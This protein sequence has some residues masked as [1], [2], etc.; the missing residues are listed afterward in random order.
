MNKITDDSTNK[1]FI[2]YEMYDQGFTLTQIA[3]HFGRS[4]NT[5]KAHIRHHPKYK[6]PK[7]GN[8]LTKDRRNTATKSKSKNDKTK[9]LSFYCPEILLERIKLT[10]G[11][12]LK[13]RYI[14]ALE[15]YLKLSFKKRPEPK[16]KAISSDK[17]VN[18]LCPE[19]LV[20]GLD[21]PDKKRIEKTGSDLNRSQKIVAALELFCESHNV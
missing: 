8:R 21:E 12:K 19:K 17:K 5:I 13:D 11:I 7:P 4:I 6:D 16:L 9:Q 2:Y 3:K 10:P 1:T 20:T 14:K 15:Q 18:F